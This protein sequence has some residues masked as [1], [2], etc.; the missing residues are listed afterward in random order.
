MTP[1]AA[2]G[3]AALD[4]P[5]AERNK[6]PILEAL[7]VHLPTRGTVLEVASG[8][9]QHVVFFAAHLPQLSWQPSERDAALRAAI[10]ARVASIGL[11]N[12]SAPLDVD[13]TAPAWPLE[14]VDAVLAINLIHIA[15]WAAA[16]G[17]V[18]GASAVL[19][20]GAPLVLYGPFRRGGRHTA[21]S[22]AAFDR[23]LRARDPEWGVRDMDAVT[24]IAAAS[25]FTLDE[26][27]ALPANNFVVVYRRD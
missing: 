15:P 1:G 5:A 3:T 14:R 16:E 9:G 10:A 27:A 2:H 23:S 25:G 18:R 12:V 22:N 21:A 24:E 26:V 7:R 6:A 11:A 20:A 13:A 8:S 4:S 19:S 17:L